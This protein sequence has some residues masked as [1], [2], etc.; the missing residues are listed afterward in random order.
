MPEL[1]LSAFIITKNES[2]DIAGCLQSLKGVA[3]EIVVVDSHS[4]DNTVEICRQAGARVIP[5]VF[6]GFGSQKQFAL[7]QTRGTW[8]LSLD[9]DER[10]TPALVYEINML[11]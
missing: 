7:D 2:A 10:L 9:A 3:H 1:G 6:D 5:R 4:T 11:I 8:A